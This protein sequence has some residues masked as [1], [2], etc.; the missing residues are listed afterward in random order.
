MAAPITYWKNYPDPY[1]PEWATEPVPGWGVRPVAVGPAKVG[2]GGY[3]AVGQ[4]A[5]ATPQQ[6]QLTL[7]KVK[8][9]VFKTLPSPEE[10]AFPGEGAQIPWWAW[11][12]GAAV[13]M[14][15]IGY[16][17]TKKRWF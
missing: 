10:G 3:V 17:G 5:I 6:Q 15:G 8:A 11:P 12:L 16:V 7:M 9:P 13:V 4:F 14:G 1:Y 2:V